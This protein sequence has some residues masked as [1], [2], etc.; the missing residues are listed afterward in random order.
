MYAAITYPAPLGAPQHSAGS[1][2]SN[3]WLNPN[4][5]PKVAQRQYQAL[6]HGAWLW[7]SEIGRT[8]FLDMALQSH[9]HP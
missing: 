7:V 6:S 5:L 1:S 2:G 9:C 3:D 4:M 8:A